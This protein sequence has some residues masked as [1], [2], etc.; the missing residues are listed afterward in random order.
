VCV[1]KT[2]GRLHTYTVVVKLRMRLEE[3]FGTIQYEVEA[4]LSYLGMDVNIVDQGTMID[5]RFYVKQVLEGETVEKFDSPRLKNMF[6]IASD[7][8]ILEEDVRKS[9]H[10]KTAKLLYLAK[11]AHPDI[12]T[13]VTFLFT[14]VQN[15]TEQDKGKLQRVLGYLKRMQDRT[16]LLRATGENRITVYV[17]AADAVHDDSKSHS[18]VVVYVGNT[19]A[20]ISHIV[21][22]TK[23]RR[24]SSDTD[25]EQ[26]SSALVRE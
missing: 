22:E 20:F 19:L 6:I 25:F 15:A 8:K 3:L 13:V 21:K 4:K 24:A 11:R 12:L 23:S 14:R 7:S 1:C 10:S 18:G 5:M 16:L 2:V 26:E 9:F 17:D